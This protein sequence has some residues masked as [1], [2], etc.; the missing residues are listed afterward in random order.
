MKKSKGELR[1]IDIE[2][3]DTVLKI[4]WI[5]R[6]SQN[7]DSSKKTLTEHFFREQGNLS[8]L[9]ICTNFLSHNIKVLARK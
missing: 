2:V 7:S 8:F 5:K 6:R 1:M 9:L 3:M 4:A